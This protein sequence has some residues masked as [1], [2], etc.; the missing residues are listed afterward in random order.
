M[1]KKVDKLI[2]WLTNK[3]YDNPKLSSKSITLIISNEFYPIMITYENLKSSSDLRLFD[4][5]NLRNSISEP[6]KTF[7]LVKNSWIYK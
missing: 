5:L 2:Q 4:D 3:E 1:I 6:Y 7:N